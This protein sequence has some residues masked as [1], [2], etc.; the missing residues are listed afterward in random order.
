MLEMLYVL[1]PRFY[2]EFKCLSVCDMIT[3]LA[4]VLFQ[5][6]F[7]SNFSLK[8]NAGRRKRLNVFKIC[9]EKK[10]EK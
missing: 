9:S 10:K 1:K 4:T 2:K 6:D 5:G 7:K 8:K 3:G